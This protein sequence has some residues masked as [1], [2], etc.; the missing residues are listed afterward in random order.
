[1]T[2][3]RPPANDPGNKP[4]RP[5]DENLAPQIWVVGLV[6]IVILLLI[7]FSIVL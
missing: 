4:Q 3:G 1:M 6:G 2:S 5:R 7:L